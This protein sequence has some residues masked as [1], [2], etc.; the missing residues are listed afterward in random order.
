VSA[1]CVGLCH[2]PFC[3]PDDRGMG[4]VGDQ[5]SDADAVMICLFL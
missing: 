1:A 3:G 2:G 4:T 5:Q